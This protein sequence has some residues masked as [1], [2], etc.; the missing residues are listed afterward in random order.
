MD[1]DDDDDRTLPR[2]TISETSWPPPPPPPPPNQYTIFRNEQRIPSTIS[3]TGL[4]GERN[5]EHTHLTEGHDLCMTV[6]LS[7]SE[8]VFP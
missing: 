3:Y 5:S 6:A 2:V 8:R 1:P 4:R 7:I